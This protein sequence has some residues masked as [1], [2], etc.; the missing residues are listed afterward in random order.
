MS[1]E[2]NISNAFQRIEKKL[3]KSMKQN[4]TRHL[5]EEAKEGFR[6]SAWQAEQLKSLEKFRKENKALFKNDFNTIN[7]DVKE[8]IKKNFEN[9]KLNQEQ[10]ILK[11]IQDGTFDSSNKKISKLWHIYKNYRHH[12]H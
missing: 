2:Y 10:L 12:L 9:G 7:D 5:N 11:S 3:I 4:L 1:N 6:W 8:L